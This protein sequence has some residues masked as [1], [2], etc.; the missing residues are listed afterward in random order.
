MSIY[1]LIEYSDNKSKTLGNLCR[2]YKDEPA[3]ANVGITDFLLIIITVFCLSL[4]KN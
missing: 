2:Y 4:Y 1:N 3:L